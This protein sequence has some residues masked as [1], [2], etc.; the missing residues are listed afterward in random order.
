MV[1]AVLFDNLGTHHRAITTKSARAQRYFDQGLILFY[2]FN[3]A[4]AQ[5]SFEEAARLDPECA[6]CWWGVGMS[7]GPHINLPAQ[8]DRTRAG[9][10]ATQRASALAARSTPV[11]RELVAALA[12]RYSDPPPADPKAQR[13]LD[14]AYAAAMREVARRFPED[15]DV[16]ALFAEALM[17]LRPWDLWSHEGDPRPETPEIVAALEAVLARNPRHPAANHYYIHAVEASAHPEKALAA[18][19]RLGELAPAA[20]HL[21]HM[22][23]HIFMRVGRYEEAAEANR[24]AIVAEDAYIEKA[25]PE[26]FHWMYVAHNPQFLMAAAAMQGRSEEALAA[27][28][29]A[30]GY[31]G[32][33]MLRHMPG[34][35]L[36][37]AYPQWM[38]VRFGRWKDV[39]AE[40]AP[41]ADFPFASAMWHA[42]RALAFSAKGNAGEAERE[43]AALAAAAASVPAEA[44]EGLNPASRLLAIATGLVGGELALRA[45]RADDGV[46]QLQEAVRQEDAL[47][48]NEPSD[49]YY[50]V[51]HHLG[52]ALLAAGR[53]AEA[54]AVYE[55]D[56]R[57][58]PENG[59]ALLG[60]AESLRAAGRTPD[61]AA[62][63]ARF[64]KAWERADV[65]LAGSRF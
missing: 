42:A 8:A 35:D 52:A 4:E 16:G 32:P 2:A 17:N 55:E 54:Q 40:A 12:R 49:W 9:H 14:E 13:A 27:A 1:A 21:V 30:V 24:R 56:L 29:R 5:R 61:A 34:L 19:G 50:P 6:S 26:G 33:E 51:R 37:L 65:A 3:L 31:L 23:A 62:A 44:T 45:G 53:T 15:D 18:A 25:K 36:G 7:L 43:R 47:N 46:R 63:R 38:L 59:W 39:L 60:L 48:Y 64:T 10:Q 22:P 41:P 20:G 28:R 58:N 57:R 11:E